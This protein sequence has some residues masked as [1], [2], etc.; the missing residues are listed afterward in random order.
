[1]PGTWDRSCG[2]PGGGRGT[3][4]QH[5]LAELRSAS[6]VYERSCTP[7]RMSPGTSRKGSARPTGYNARTA[8]LQ[9]SGERGTKT[10][11]FR[12]PSVL[13][14]G[15]SLIRILANHTP[16]LL[17]LN[18]DKKCVCLS[19]SLGRDSIE[20]QR[21]LGEPDVR[22]DQLPCAATCR[23][24]RHRKSQGNQSPLPLRRWAEL[25][26][27]R[28]TAQRLAGWSAPPSRLA[29]RWWSVSAPGWPQMWQ[30]PRSRATT[31]PASLRWA[32]GGLL[33]SNAFRCAPHI[34]PLPGG[35][36]GTS[37]ISLAYSLIVR[38]EENQ[39]MCAVLRAAACHQACL[40]RQRRNTDRWA[41]K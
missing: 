35:R 30:M 17:R 37:Q 21:L 39:P 22:H 31:D 34:Y 14:N 11:Y 2:F 3:G 18:C 10:S 12:L 33:V 4:F 5:S 9:I 16:T 24:S 32:R 38:S 7:R 25:W 15:P 19:V 8:D 6:R 41:S 13:G 40:S 29:I 20:L 26:Q 27:P 23:R 36:T 1:M 28:W